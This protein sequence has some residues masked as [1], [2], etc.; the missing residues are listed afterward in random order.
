MASKWWFVASLLLCL[1]VASAAARATMPRDCDTTAAFAAG[2]GSAGAV[3]EDDEQAKTADVFGGRTGGGGV[4]GPLGGGVAGF[5]PFGGAVAQR[6]RSAG[7][8]AAAA[9]VVEEVQVATASR[10]AS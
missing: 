6:A 10:E 2:D 5:G 8:E 4:H 1:A 7:S 3:D 9:S